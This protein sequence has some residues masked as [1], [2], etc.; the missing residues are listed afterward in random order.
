MSSLSLLSLSTPRGF[1][2]DRRFA[3]LLAAA[4]AEPAAP[5]R[6][7]V[8]E[9]FERG[10]AL[11]HSEALELAEQRIAQMEEA[12]QT[13]DLAFAR[14]DDQSA[15]DLRERLR[16][17]VLALCEEAIAPLAIDPDGLRMR[18]ERAVAILQ[19]R[20]DEIRIRL[21]PD[22]RALVAGRLPEG[23]VLEADPEME[24]GALRVDTVDGGVEDGP[25]QWRA[26]LSE[27]LGGC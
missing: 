25:A 7:P 16:L 8:E 9:A 3:S 17:T 24:R 15:A 26:I 14:L 5:R 1:A 21:H 4:D 2:V 11:G 27:A 6:D 13:I 12:R 22:D 18:I 19:R 23:L 20:Q 10:R